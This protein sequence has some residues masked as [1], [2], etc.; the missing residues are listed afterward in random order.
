[1]WFFWDVTVKVKM[2]AER[3]KRVARTRRIERMRR[4]VD[5]LY[6]FSSVSILSTHDLIFEGASYLSLFVSEGDE[7]A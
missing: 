3:V 5:V 1:M 2:R 4:R 6:S 7:H